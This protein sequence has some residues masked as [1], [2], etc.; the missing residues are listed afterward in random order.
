MCAKSVGIV[1]S[2]TILKNHPFVESVE[3]EER[4]LAHEKS[5]DDDVFPLEREPP[6][7]AEEG[8]VR[9]V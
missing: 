7:E 4:E 5:T 9:D 8:G 6:K 2:K 3:Q 1:S